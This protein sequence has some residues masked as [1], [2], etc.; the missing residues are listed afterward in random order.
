MK[1]ACR[2]LSVTLACL[3]ILSFAGCMDNRDEAMTTSDTGTTSDILSQ[4]TT[5]PESV[6]TFVD[7]EAETTTAQ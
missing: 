4:V 7:T 1:N 5:A 6:S 3:I 2:L